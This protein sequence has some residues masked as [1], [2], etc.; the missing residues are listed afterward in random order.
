[1]SVMASRKRWFT[2][3]RCLRLADPLRA[4]YSIIRVCQHPNTVHI[5]L[6]TASKSCK[7][8]PIIHLYVF[9]NAMPI[10]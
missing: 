4:V 6:Q 3:L 7:L 5:P 9:R 10:A 8:V 1:M 2:L